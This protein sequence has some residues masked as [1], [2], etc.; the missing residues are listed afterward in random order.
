M[1]LLHKNMTVEEFEAG[2]FYARELKI[3]A[4]E[5]GLSPGRLRKFEIEERIK[6]YLSTGA[7][8]EEELKNR[9]TPREAGDI[10]AIDSPVKNYNGNRKTKAFLL[11]LVQRRDPR[12]KDK[13]G[14]WYWLNDWRRKQMEAGNLFTYGDLADQL[15]KL[16]KTKGRLPQIPS[17]RMNNFISD[18]LADPD[19]TGKKRS[20]AQAAWEQA[21]VSPGTKSYSAYKIRIS[22]SDSA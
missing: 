9:A 1:S 11:E 18:F 4:R 16:R 3:F 13:S 15:L 20:D 2:Y 7:L 12:T 22:G 14:Q 10:L 5:I 6:T 17:A 21:K 19:N 8:P